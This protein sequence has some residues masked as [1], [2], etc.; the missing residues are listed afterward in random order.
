MDPAEYAAMPETLEVRVIRFTIHEPGRRTREIEVVTTLT[1]AE[2][3]S[4]DD[5]AE[6]YGFRWNTELDIR[7]IKSTLN[8]DHLRCKTPAMVLAEVWATI[9]AYNLIR[10][11]VAGSGG[12]PRQAAAADQFH[13]SVPIHPLH[14]DDALCQPDTC[15]HLAGTPPPAA[16]TDRVVRR[17]Q[18]ARSIRTSRHQTSQAPL[19]ADETTQSRSPAT[20]SQHQR[21]EWVTL[22]T[23][24]F[25]PGTFFVHFFFFAGASF[26]KTGRRPP[27]GR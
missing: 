2:A 24:P 27:I 16:R 15:G 18:P 6:L 8:L 9:L 19:S 3:Y 22:S 7:S 12:T 1:D 23:V 20:A 5:I 26:S 14:M 21:P 10:T 17:R 11:T 25:V 4:R 13:R